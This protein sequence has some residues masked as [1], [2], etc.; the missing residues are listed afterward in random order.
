MDKE[1]DRYYIKIRTHLGIDAKTIH[2]ELATA[3]GSDAPPYRT[4]ARW[5]QL[6]REGRED[7]HDDPRSGRPVSEMTA[8]NIELVRQAINNDPHSTYDEIM[9]ETYLSYGTIERIIHDCLKLRKL[10]SRWVPCRLTDEQKQQRVKICR[11]NLAKFRDG[12]WRLC[13]IITG[14]ETWIYNRQIHRKS[15]NKSWVGEGGSPTTT[16]RRRKFEPKPLFCLFFKSN[17]PVLVHAVDEG[18]TVDRNYYIENCLKPVV[19]EIWKQRKSTGTKGIKLLHDNARPHAHADVIDYL[20]EEG[21]NIMPHPPYSPDLAPCDYW[22]NDY[23]KCN[24]AD[25]PDKESLARAVSKVVKNIPQEEFK[26][27]FDKLLE[28]MEL[29]ISNCGDFFEHLIK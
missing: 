22:L 18:K 15:T 29:C 4:V 9:A 17:G 25:Q 10:T 14:D 24:L 28:R 20:K 6:F 13:D 21:I 16:V 12:S 2:E 26:K 3:K 7:V 19:K 11:E 1:F 23:I 8:E 5:T 27:A